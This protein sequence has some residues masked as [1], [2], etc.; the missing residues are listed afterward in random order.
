M[1]P[2][3]PSTIE[4]LAELSALLADPFTDRGAAL[5]KAGLDEERYEALA[6]QLSDRLQRD[7]AEE[8]E[9]AARFARA[10]EKARVVARSERVGA[11]GADGE[12]GVSAEPGGEVVD[13]ARFLSA[14]QPWRS[15]AASVRIDAEGDAPELRRA[16]VVTE[17]VAAGDAAS[18]RAPAEAN[19]LRA[20]SPVPRPAVDPIAAFRPDADAT[21]TAVPTLAPVLPFLEG[22]RQPASI[23][24]PP[25]SPPPQRPSRPHANTDETAEL[26]SI[27]LG[28][29]TP[30]E[31]GGAPSGEA[32][33]SDLDGTCEMR[34][35]PADPPLP[36]SSAP[37]P[38]PT[39]ATRARLARFDPQTGEPLPEPRWVEDGPA[40]G[41]SEDGAMDTR[42]RR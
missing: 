12:R 30:F 13:G 21:C 35:L 15:E 10:F 37:T 38:T 41:G 27:A 6:R 25:P 8:R 7:G 14:A 11:G 20:S 19:E 24:A 1:S 18:E 31:R 39:P 4:A 2:T 28:P 36:F 26:G 17:W 34:V 40:A 5:T 33:A 9:M 42:S 16:P 3:S 22:L 23:P 29:A 32:A